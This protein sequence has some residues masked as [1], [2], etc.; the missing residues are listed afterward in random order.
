MGKAIGLRIKFIR[1]CIGLSQ[2]KL[3]KKVGLTA[4]AI[5]Q[6]E[7]S[8]RNPDFESLQKLKEALQV[9]W[10]VLLNNADITEVKEE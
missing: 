1:E 10:D 3:A 7:N 9:G 6:Y 8:E 5:S 4:A 2:S